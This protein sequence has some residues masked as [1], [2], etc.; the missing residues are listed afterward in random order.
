MKQR[1]WG[2]E[3]KR[4]IGGKRKG[5]RERASTGQL[6]GYPR[7]NKKE[8]GGKGERTKFSSCEGGTVYEKGEKRI[9]R[10][11]DGA[12]KKGG[13]GSPDSGRQHNDITDTPHSNEHEEEKGW[14][15]SA[16][17]QKSETWSNGDSG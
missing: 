5:G 3:N 2:G 17:E 13:Q 15:R 7:H 11:E 8:G 10:G 9:G 6:L 12:P 16:T 1:I 4:L 14:L